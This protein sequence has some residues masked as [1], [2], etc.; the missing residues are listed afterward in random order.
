MYSFSFVPETYQKDTEYMALISDLLMDEAVQDLDLIVHHIHTTRLRHCLFV[1]YMSYKIAK[2]HDLDYKAV[3]RAGLLHD[4]FLE[5]R[6]EIEDMQEGSH[7]EVHPKI[8]LENARKITEISDLEADII[9]SHMFLTCTK[10][11][12]PRY[13][14][15]RL[16]S[17][18]DKY[19]A[20]SEFFMPVK[21]RT[22][23][24]LKY[25]RFA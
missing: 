5:D 22:R 15:S 20:I 9:L 8:A 1:S 10:A 14:E 7:A 17:M 16:V 13:P 25:I 2:A 12:K 4:F 3:A 24:I 11:P 19:C 21:S 18:M 23:L 6:Q